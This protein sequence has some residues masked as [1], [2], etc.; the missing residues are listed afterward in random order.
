MT[1]EAGQVQ[2]NGHPDHLNS[3]IQLRARE[4]LRPGALGANIG[5][6]SLERVVQIE[7]PATTSR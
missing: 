4:L 1:E 3:V 6:P 2:Y 5:G 7:G